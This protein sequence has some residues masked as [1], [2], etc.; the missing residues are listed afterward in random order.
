MDRKTLFQLS[1][2]LYIVSTK[3]NDK[4]AGCVVNT[5]T[6]LTSTP[7]TIMVCINKDNF[8]NHCINQ[9]KEFA[10]SILSEKVK[11][12]IIGDFG[13]HSS[14]DK[15]KFADLSYTLTPSGIPYLTEGVC[16]FLQCKVINAIDNYTHTLFIAE[17]QNAEI[18]SKET[19]LT[20]SY[21]HNVIKGKTPPKASSFN[22]DA[23]TITT[24][25]TAKYK[26]SVC[27]YIY[28]NSK[29]EFELLPSD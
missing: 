3:N 12:S 24:Q 27:G 11:E 18:L 5:I 6:Q 2:G 23:E 22:P 13:F 28:P 15:N 20:Y 17:V 29:E 25:T 26:C 7:T 16:G 4:F 14:K 21:Y 9:T 8:T 1:Y 19:P 10:V